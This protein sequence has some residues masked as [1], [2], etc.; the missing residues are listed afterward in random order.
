M[1]PAAWTVASTGR[2]ISSSASSLATSRSSPAVPILL[3]QL[4]VFLL[5]RVG[6]PRHHQPLSCHT[7][8]DQPL[9]KPGE[10]H[11]ALWAAE[12]RGSLLGEDQD[13]GRPGGRL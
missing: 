1:T 13:C 2:R 9:S 12:G 8:P 11:G 5:P 3:S 7:Q 10:P 6:R 4:S